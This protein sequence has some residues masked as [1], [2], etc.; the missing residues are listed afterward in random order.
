MQIQARIARDLLSSKVICTYSDS[1]GFSYLSDPDNIAKV[2]AILAPMGV[3]IVMTA[4]NHAFYAA[5]ESVEDASRQLRSQYQSLATEARRMEEIIEFVLNVFP[6]GRRMHV[7]QIIESSRVLDGVNNSDALSEMLAQVCASN[8][9]TSHTNA[10]RITN[11][12]SRLAGDGYLVPL[13]TEKETYVVSGMIEYIWDVIEN[14]ARLIP[15]IAEQL[16]A[17]DKQGDLFA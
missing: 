13:N 17:E 15:D 1:A 8:K 9:M 12:F 14:F 7:G 3:R 6:D 10:L 4:N 5:E 2:E 11:L 16:P